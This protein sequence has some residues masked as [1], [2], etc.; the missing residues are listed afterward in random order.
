MT[1]YVKHHAVDEV[2]AEPGMRDITAHVDFSALSHAGEKAGLTTLGFVD[3]QRFLMGVA[4]DELSGVGRAHRWKSK[5]ILR[6]WNTLTHPEHLGADFFALV[7]VKDAPDETRRSPLR[8][9]GMARIGQVK[10]GA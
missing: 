8:A 4:H 2:L 5:K 6:A 9:T 3:Q 10:R 7:Q 1:A